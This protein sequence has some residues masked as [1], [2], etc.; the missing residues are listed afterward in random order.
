M[1]NPTGQIRSIKIVP[2][3]HPHQR[4]FQRAQSQKNQQ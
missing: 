3:K 2:A 1:Q 4:K